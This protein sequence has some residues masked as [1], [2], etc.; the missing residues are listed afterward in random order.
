M[1]GDGKENPPNQL[2]WLETFKQEL[3]A[4][5]VE[6]IENIDKNLDEFFRT[7]LAGRNC[8]LTVQD[9]LEQL[10]QGKR[11]ESSAAE[12]IFSIVDTIALTA[13]LPAADLFFRYVME[14]APPPQSEDRNMPQYIRHEH[15][16]R[17]VQRM[18]AAIYA[19]IE[20]RPFPLPE[21][22]AKISSLLGR[23]YLA[24]ARAASSEDDED[25]DI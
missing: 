25:K 12:A 2:P 20:K 18:R 21:D 9:I 15:A 6:A 1:P 4:R 23:L 7:T 14:N 3:D 19:Q 5:A 16:L 10:E 17:R 24:T 11:T 13:A 22:Y 8:M